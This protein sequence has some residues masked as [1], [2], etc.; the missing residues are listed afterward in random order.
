MPELGMSFVAAL[1]RV[2]AWALNKQIWVDTDEAN[3]TQ[4][5][6]STTHRPP[7]T[8]LIWGIHLANLTEAAA[9]PL[10]GSG[11][12]GGSGTEAGAAGGGGAGVCGPEVRA[13][14]GAALRGRVSPFGE[15][16]GRER[17]GNVRVR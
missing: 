13:D 7:C 9:L 10:E 8:M 5:L 1:A 15:R 3:A 16:K 12:G 6:R 14:A 4:A 11:G 2:F 17:G